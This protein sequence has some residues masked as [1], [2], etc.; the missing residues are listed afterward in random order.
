MA[1]DPFGSVEN[2]ILRAQYNFIRKNYRHIFL[3]SQ[4]KIL[5]SLVLNKVSY[6]ESV[7]ELPHLFFHVLRTNKLLY[8]VP[9]SKCFHTLDCKS[10]DFIVS[11]TDE[12]VEAK[13]TKLLNL[14]CIDHLQE[15]YK[16]NKFNSQLTLSVLFSE[17]SHSDILETIYIPILQSLNFKKDN[18]FFLSSQDV[19]QFEDALIFNK[20]LSVYGVS[21]KNFSISYL[22]ALEQQLLYVR[23]NTSVQKLRI[24]QML[25]QI[26]RERL[27]IN[28]IVLKKKNVKPDQNQLLHDIVSDPEL[29][30][31]SNIKES[32]D[33]FLGDGS[34]GYPEVD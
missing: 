19:L 30:D 17:K 8:P 24:N 5:L 20:I 15:Q 26:E 34:D 3:T 16:L 25:R 6:D 29:N 27:Q 11:G 13:T 18:C 9:S 33:I 1:S 31:N 4:D 28:G 7:F 22:D 2:P 10:S 12:L 14:T 32:A 21:R 23:E